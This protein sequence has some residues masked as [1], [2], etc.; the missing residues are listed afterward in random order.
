MYKPTLKHINKCIMFYILIL[1]Y[2]SFSDLK[3]SGS[4]R[5]LH[6]ISAKLSIRETCDSSV[7][8][9]ILVKNLAK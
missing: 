4:K 8:I 5:T 2:N 3:G 9:W 1:K 6:I 7:N